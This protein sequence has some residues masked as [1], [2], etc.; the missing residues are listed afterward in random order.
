MKM[1]TST[2]GIRQIELR[3][4]N[5]LKAYKDTVGVPTICTGHTTAAGKPVVVMGMK[6]TLAQCEE[7]LRRDLA[8]VEI[9]VNRLVK[10]ALTQNQ[11]DALV[12]FVFNIGW[13]HFSTSTLLKKLNKG[14]YKG[15][16]DQFLVWVKQP[17]LKGR[18]V[19]ERA[20]FLA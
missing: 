14:D 20:Q 19:K 6:L 17:E 2:N 15:A 8:D 1:T 13:P 7:I 11:F 16:A 4:G 3:E 18:R 5:M 9:Y 12:S 10:V